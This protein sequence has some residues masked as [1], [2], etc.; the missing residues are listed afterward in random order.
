MDASP[1]HQYMMR[2]QR[3]EVHKSKSDSTQPKHVILTW[4][5]Y[6]QPVRPSKRNANTKQ[7]LRV[8]TFI[9]VTGVRLLTSLGSFLLV[10]RGSSSLFSGLFLLCRSLASRSFPRGGRFLFSFRR[11]FRVTRWMCV[12]SVSL[13][14]DLGLGIDECVCVCVCVRGRIRARECCRECLCGMD[15]KVRSDGVLYRADT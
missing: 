11:H 5:V 9:N 8:I 4:R 15:Q 1:P 10:P 13:W 7:K 14:G 2:P 6:P 3:L 12:G